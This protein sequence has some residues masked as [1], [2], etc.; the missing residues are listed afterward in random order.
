[1]PFGLCNAPATFERLMG[2]VLDGLSWKTCLVYL[3]DVIVFGKDFETTLTRLSEVFDR[4]RNAGLK[5]SPKKCELFQ[6]SVAYLGHIVT[7]EGVKVDPTKIEA[8]RN[9]PV[10]TNVT[11]LRGFIGLCSYYRKFI[12]S[13][14]KI[15]RPLHSLAEKS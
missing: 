2:K 7:T 9:W 3:D 10:P 15:A 1:M 6:R 13:F 12:R 4:L 14:A 8:I 5:L 11:E